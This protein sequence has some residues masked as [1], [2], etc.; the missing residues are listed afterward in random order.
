MRGLYYPSW[1]YH[2][3]EAPRLVRNRDED[4]GLGAGWAESPAAFE[5]KAPAAEAQ[6]E[7]EGESPAVIDVEREPEM[8]LE[9][10]EVDEL[11]A[12]A[13]E[14]GIHVHSRSGKQKIIE[15]LQGGGHA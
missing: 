13:K 6:P 1:R 5:G 10:M 3:T 7:A 9:A 8:D 12:L 2:Q 4:E 15:A 11:R 14:R